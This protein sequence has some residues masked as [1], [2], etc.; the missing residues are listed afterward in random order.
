[1]R[2]E[3]VQNGKLVSPVYSICDVSGCLLEQSNLTVSCIHG[4]K[5][6]LIDGMDEAVA[7][8]RAGDSVELEMQSESGDVKTSFVTK[9]DSGQL[10]V[11][12]NRPYAGRDH[13]VMAQLKEVRDPIREEPAQEKT[14]LTPPH[15]LH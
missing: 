6:E 12:G 7:K 2:S 14:T 11:D 4:G 9:V 8:T 13:R 15:G 5:R 1:M 3:R 10:S